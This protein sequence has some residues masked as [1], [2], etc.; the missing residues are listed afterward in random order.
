[1][2]KWAKARTSGHTQTLMI[3]YGQAYHQVLQCYQQIKDHSMLHWFKAKNP[4]TKNRL[5]SS[6]ILP[7]QQQYQEKNKSK[8]D[9]EQEPT[10]F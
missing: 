7:Q 4:I 9:G 2:K 6:H 8:M 10:R 1:M 3:L 5:D